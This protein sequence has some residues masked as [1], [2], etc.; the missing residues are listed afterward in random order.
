MRCVPLKYKLIFEKQKIFYFK[1]T[2][3]P[4]TFVL[5]TLLKLLIYY[6]FF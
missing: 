5:H 1:N 6:A 3:L 4:P 2:Y